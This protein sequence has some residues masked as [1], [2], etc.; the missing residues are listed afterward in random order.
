M[1]NPIYPKIDDTIPNY[2]KEEYPVFHKLIVDYYKWLETDE[3]FLH[4]LI[5]FADDIEVNNQI[6]PYIDIIKNELGWNYKIQ[7]KID[8]RTLIRLLRDFYLSRGTE[9]SFKILFKILFDADV[10]L[11]YPRDQLLKLSDNN[12]IIE[13]EIITTA[14]NFKNDTDLQ[15]RFSSSDILNI[16]ITG[17]E[18]GLT[19]VVD[20]IYPI[21]KANEVY[22][23]ILVSK[24]NNDFIPFE[25]VII[26]SEE[27]GSFKE[28]IYCKLSPV[29]IDSGYNYKQNEKLLIKNKITNNCDFIDG[30]ILI[31]SVTTGGI[32]S[33]GI[34]RQIVDNRFIYST[35]Q[36]YKS[37]DRVLA[38]DPS[39]K[40]FFGKIVTTELKQAKINLA[41]IDGEISTLTIDQTGLGYLLAP[42]ITVL[43]TRNPPKG[44]GA[45]FICENITAKNYIAD[46]T[47]ISGGINYTE[48]PVIVEIS[49]PNS[50]G[51][52]ATATAEISN[53]A[54]SKII[55]TNPGLLYTDPSIIVRQGGNTSAIIKLILMGSV[56]NIIKLD[57]GQNYDP[58]F[59]TIVF[60]SP[61]S[62]QSW[63]RKPTCNITYL[64]GRLNPIITDAGYGYDNIPD[65]Q[66]INENLG[67]DFNLSLGLNNT[68]ITI[69]D[70][71]PGYNYTN[72]VELIVDSPTNE[73]RIEY[74]DITNSGYNFIDFDETELIISTDAGSGAELYPFSKSIG[75][76]NQFIE[77]DSYWVYSYDKNAALSFDFEI[78]SNNGLNSNITILANSCINRNKRYFEN[79]RGLLEINAFLHDSYYYQQFSYLLS[80]EYP[81]KYSK[82]IIDDLLHPVGFLKFS[83][84][85]S[86]NLWNYPVI[87]Q[88]TSDIIHVIE[89]NNIVDFESIIIPTI[90]SSYFNVFANEY[91][92][93]PTT[94]IDKFNVFSINSILE[95]VYNSDGTLRLYND[96][97]TVDLNHFKDHRIRDFDYTHPELTELAALDAEIEQIQPD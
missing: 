91:N 58:N 48:D 62:Q 25:Q 59:T 11:S 23:R 88:I 6:K 87:T 24:T 74:I 56:T 1:R 12:F 18:S 21:I 17:I 97:F 50:G 28:R 34:N 44:F 54:V 3:N 39:G 49:A 38:I 43:D 40:G 2:I 93:A 61:D 76:I 53:G 29:I 72:G 83:S 7:L 64:S 69:D 31:K 47:I 78:V 80:S 4:A 19:L 84:F 71:E 81:S 15:A 13:H 52:Q 68:G 32:N 33:I 95:I 85:T 22:L 67:Q 9:Q 45:N 63:A 57:G 35:G 86:D 8:D 60:D 77:L 5:N 65:F 37:N 46:Y 82:N 94:N 96:N 27:I 92:D 26:Y 51:I 66:I 10:K 79:E 42:N 36:N 20:K 70:F 90:T 14:N 30:N 55:I 73:G 75:K 41:I 16:T 89:L